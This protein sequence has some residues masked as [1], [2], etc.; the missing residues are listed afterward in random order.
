[1]RAWSSWC[2]TSYIL[3]PDELFGRNDYLNEL[4]VG[5]QSKGRWQ[6]FVI[7]DADEVVRGADGHANKHLARLLNLTDGLLGSEL[8]VAFLITTNERLTRLHPALARPGRCLAEIEIGQLSGEAVREWLAANGGGAST[9]GGATLA[10]LYEQVGEGRQIT[11]GRTAEGG[12][13][14]YL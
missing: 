8:N 1:M 6:L 4:V 3:D 11:G 7:E 14:L 12:T 5:E 13:G 10:E 9:L 2:D